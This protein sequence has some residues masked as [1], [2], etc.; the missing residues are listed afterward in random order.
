MLYIAVHVLAD[1]QLALYPIVSLFSLQTQNGIMCMCSRITLA[2][3]VMNY[4]ASLSYNPL[5][6]LAALPRFCQLL[7]LFIFDTLCLSENHQLQDS[8]AQEYCRH[9]YTYFCYLG[10][11]GVEW[12][13]ARK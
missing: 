3:D 8:Q 4:E 10:K 6:E 1:C 9:S 2:R 7:I 12:A 11:N 13:W 5:A